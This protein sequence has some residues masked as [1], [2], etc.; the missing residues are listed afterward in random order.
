MRGYI[1]SC[2]RYL[3][4]KMWTANGPNPMP[5][6][7]DPTA[8]PP[9][10]AATLGAGPMMGAPAPMLPPGA[11]PPAMMPMPNGGVPAQ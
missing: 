8:L 10:G 11:P 3:T 7:P 9:P 2:Y 1:K 6:E 4:G 5:G